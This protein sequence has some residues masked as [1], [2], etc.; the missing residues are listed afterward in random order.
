MADNVDSYW[1]RRRGIKRSMAAAIN[2]L[3]N[4]EMRDNK[5]NDVNCA[6][7]PLGTPCDYPNTACN[8]ADDLMHILETV[9][10]TAMR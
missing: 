10:V 7:S 9:A 4:C 3:K 1:T 6:P 5:I 2:E 8:E